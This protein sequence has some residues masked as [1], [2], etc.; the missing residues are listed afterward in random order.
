MSAKGFHVPSAD[1][2]LRR[3]PKEFIGA[4]IGG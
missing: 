4:G 2:R 3:N 1:A